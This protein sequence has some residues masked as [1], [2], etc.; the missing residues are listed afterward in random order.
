MFGALGA[1]IGIT[2]SENYQDI[3]I[4]DQVFSKYGAKEA[5]REIHT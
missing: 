5:R 4:G 2:E 1:L 3:I